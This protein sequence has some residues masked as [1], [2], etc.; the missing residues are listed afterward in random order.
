MPRAPTIAVDFEARL[1]NVGVASV[2]LKFWDTAGQEAF[3]SIIKNF[4]RGTEVVLLVFS[5]SSRDS[6]E[7][8]DQWLSDFSEAGPEQAAVFLV[9]SKADL[10]WQVS[11]EEINA[12]VLSRPRINK[13]V[14]CS[15]LT[16]RDI[17][18]LLGLIIEF[19]AVRMSEL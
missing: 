16:G 12:Y 7:L 2:Q 6:F 3:R 11:L 5:V 8:V 13:A 18:V 1:V 19:K 10:P 9:A 4:Y 14:A 15:A 17:D